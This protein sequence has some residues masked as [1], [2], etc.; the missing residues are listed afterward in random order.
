[1]KM[2]DPDPDPLL[3][4]L[5]SPAPTPNP[6]RSTWP[7]AP[8]IHQPQDPQPPSLDLPID[9]SLS[10]AP[11]GVVEI[12]A[13]SESAHGGQGPM[14]PP[15]HPPSAPQAPAAQQSPPAQDNPQP[16]SPTQIDPDLQEMARALFPDLAKDL[17]RLEEQRAGSQACEARPVINP[18]ATEPPE[19]TI[20]TAASKAIHPM[21]HEAI[22]ATVKET[23]LLRSRIPASQ[24][25]KQIEA[26]GS[27]HGDQH[28]S[29]FP[30]PHAYNTATPVKKAVAHSNAASSSN[31]K[32]HQMNFANDEEGWEPARASH[33]RREAEL[34]TKII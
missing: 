3:P 15:A 28:L 5:V 4:F 16:A 8:P 34:E 25:G 20:K 23:S 11:Q 19:L 1:M 31:R 6:S 18:P 7:L 12:E 27:I 2:E 26:P 13:V 10:V 9:G 14:A 24:K 32:D 22:E 30:V 33:R 21:V 29:S 17:K